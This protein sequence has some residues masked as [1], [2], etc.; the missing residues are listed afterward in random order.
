MN[1]AISQPTFLPWSGYIALLDYI[2]E[3]VFLDNVQ[4]EKRSWQ[5]RNNIK[6]SSGKLIITIP[7]LSKNLFR[8]K[9]NEV[10]IDYSNNFLNKMIKTIEQNYSKTSYFKDYANPLF[11]IFLSKPEKLIDLNISLIK[12]ICDNLKIDLN[13]SLASELNISSEKEKL[14]QEICK[15]KKAS[16]YIS[17]LGA[18]NYLEKENFYKNSGAKLIFYNYK[19]KEH[20]QINGKF[21]EKLS[22]IDLMF[23]NGPKSKQILRENFILN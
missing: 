22:V 4:F 1:I 11:D 15:I 12:W 3:I 14:I 18:I 16:K 21:V 17:T 19:N 20:K 23:N 8:Q 7:V 6:S 2:N 13:Y 5:Q 9:I 10:K